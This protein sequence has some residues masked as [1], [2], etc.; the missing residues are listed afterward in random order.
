LAE[1]ID[2]GGRSNFQYRLNETS[3]KTQ[4]LLDNG[5]LSQK[6]FQL[7]KSMQR[8]VQEVNLGYAFVTYSHSV[9]FITLT[10]R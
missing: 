6:D 1:S 4:E 10:C 5:I 7:L 2:E 8:D 3:G 9:R